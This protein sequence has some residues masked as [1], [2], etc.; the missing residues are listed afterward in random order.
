MKQKTF[1]LTTVLACL[2]LAGSISAKEE[3]SQPIGKIDSLQSIVKEGT[4]A[5]LNWKISYPVHKFN[6]TDSLVTVRFITAAVGPKWRI[7][8]GTRTNGAPY[9]EFYHGFTEDHPSYALSPE[10][11]VSETLV[12][13]NEEIEF[14]L[15]HEASKIPGAWV[16]S[17]N[18][19]HKDQVIELH[20]GDQVPTVA[21]AG[22]QR[23]VAEIL[24]PYSENGIV[25]IGENQRIILFEIYT[26]DKNS[27]GFDLQDVVLL[28]S[29]E[30]VPLED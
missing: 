7:N 11:I 16:S 25:T 17:L 5:D 26:T 14:L 9:E 12:S 27:P 29:H 19:A 23:S 13:A 1:P 21:G 3:N 24:A 10:L 2:S 28:V 4:K 22:D 15:R 6:Q 30:Q 18:P 8:F 20:K